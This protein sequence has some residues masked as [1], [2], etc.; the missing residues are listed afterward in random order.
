MGV[1]RLVHSSLKPLSAE[2]K[3]KGVRG[4]GGDGG[5][6][7]KKDKG[8]WVEKKNKCVIGFGAR[9][10]ERERE[11]E[12]DDNSMKMVIFKRE[13]PTNRKYNIILNRMSQICLCQK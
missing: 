2:A 10:R 12:R 8:K 9:E 1:A 6:D 11:T 7:I 5:V 4:K 3:R 13:S